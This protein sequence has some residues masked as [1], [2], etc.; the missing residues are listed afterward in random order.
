MP[1]AREFR[2][3]LLFVLGCCAGF[4]CESAHYV[5]RSPDSGVVAIPRDTPELRAKAEKLMHEQFPAGYVVD[6]VRVVPYGR[7]YRTITQ[8]GPFAEVE[9]HRRHEVM[10][11]YHAGLPGLA[12]PIQTG[13]PV[14]AS[15]PTPAMNSAVVPASASAPAAPPNGLPAQPIPVGQ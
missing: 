3:G 7:P 2:S 12:M 6:D 1:A 5:V 14:V 8:V 10:L 11:Y 15:P 4:G 9:T 13:T